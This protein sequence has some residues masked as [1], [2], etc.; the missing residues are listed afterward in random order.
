MFQ[1]E[2]PVRG[3]TKP[4]TLVATDNIVEARI[5]QIWVACLRGVFPVQPRSIVVPLSDGVSTSHEAS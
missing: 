2:N 5:E 1:E 3:L 4:L